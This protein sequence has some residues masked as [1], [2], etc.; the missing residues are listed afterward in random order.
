MAQAVLQEWGSHL[1][2]CIPK[3]MAGH[4]ALAKGSPVTIQNAWQG[5][6]ITPR[7]PETLEA[8]LAK[9]NRNNL[10]QEE[11]SDCVGKEAW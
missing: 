10:H 7:A 2:V 11:F 8:L 9:V 1:A 3:R 6:Y 5:I 4:F